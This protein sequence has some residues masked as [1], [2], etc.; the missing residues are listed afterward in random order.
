MR[1]LSQSG[2]VRRAILSKLMFVY[3]PKHGSWLNVAEIEPRGRPRECIN[4][5]RVN[6]RV[7]SKAEF[8]RTAEAAASTGLGR[9]TQR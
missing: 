3:T 6:G 8:D 5:A 1:S 4:A 9:A 7:A 2:P